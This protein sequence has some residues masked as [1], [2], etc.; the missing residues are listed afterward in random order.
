MI[1]MINLEDE[2]NKID[3]PWSPVDLVRINDHVV[4]MALFDGEYIWR[5]SWNAPR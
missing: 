1:S 5:T 3:K 4:R 2:T